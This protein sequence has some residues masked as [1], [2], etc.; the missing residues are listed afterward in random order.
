VTDSSGRLSSSKRVPP[1]GGAARSG[2]AAPC[3][4]ERRG[5]TLHG[6]AR[7]SVLHAS[8][9][10]WSPPNDGAGSPS[11]ATSMTRAVGSNVCAARIALRVRGRFGSE[12]A[13]RSSSRRLRPSALALVPAWRLSRK[14]GPRVETS[15]GNRWLPMRGEGRSRPEPSRLRCRAGVGCK[16]R[17]GET[18][19]PA[20]R[21]SCE[22]TRLRARLGFVQPPR[23]GQSRR[24]R[25]RRRRR[26]GI[27]PKGSGEGHPPRPAAWKSE[28][29]RGSV[30]KRSGDGHPA[31]S[32]CTDGRDPL[33]NR[34]E[35]RREAHRPEALLGRSHLFGGVATRAAGKGTAWNQRSEGR[36][37][38][39]RGSVGSAMAKGTRLESMHGRP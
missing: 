2:F 26:S 19:Q 34:T 18:A 8:S 4:V 35:K 21:G 3:R 5:T 24:F 11:A 32:R 10:F 14:R 30:P 20:G 38:F 25:R 28:P 23:V 13:L 29:P 33:G 16:L 6:V 1:S 15:R 36:L 37:P 39:W 12:R 9:T 27:G 7:S 31:W 22:E 17:V